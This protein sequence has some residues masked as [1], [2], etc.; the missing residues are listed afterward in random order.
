MG[1]MKAMIMD[2]EEKLDE[3]VWYIVSE[4]ETKQEF[5]NKVSDYIKNNNIETL[6]YYADGSTTR[7]SLS[8]VWNEYWSKYNIGGK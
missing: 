8:D 2:Q 7:G 5:A 6:G 3:Y 1:R 4:C